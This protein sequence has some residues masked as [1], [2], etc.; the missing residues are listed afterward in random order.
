MSNARMSIE[1]EARN[2]NGCAKQ[3]FTS[4][5]GALR[6]KREMRMGVRSRGVSTLFGGWIMTTAQRLVQELKENGLR[7]ATA[8]SCT[9]GMIA[10]KIVDVSGASL[11]FEEGYITYSN[12][13]KEKVLGVSSDTIS[14]HSVVSHEVAEEMAAGVQRKTEADIAISV[15]GYAG[16]EPADDGTPAGTVYIG[17][18][19]MKQ[20]KS[21]H[22][23]FKGTRQEVR[24]QAAQVALSLALDTLLEGKIKNE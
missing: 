20:T 4:A 15:T 7:I 6:A 18:C 24:E 22:F 9:G 23:C 21:Q 2:A 19:Y 8:E 16:P 5:E 17:I 3:S 10:S 11:V 13:V 14:K 12:R 1:S